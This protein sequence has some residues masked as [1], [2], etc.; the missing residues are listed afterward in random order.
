MSYGIA[1]YGTDGKITFHSDYSSVVYVGEVAKNTTPTQPVYTGSHH[2]AI[3]SSLKE[4][5]SMM[6][7]L[8]LSPH[9]MVKL[10]V[11]IPKHGSKA[12]YHLK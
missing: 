4:S 12:M 1:A 2:I 3:S 6:Q 5:N 10:T 7:I 11:L 9:Q 8:C